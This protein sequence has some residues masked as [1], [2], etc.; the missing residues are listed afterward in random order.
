MG[1]IVGSVYILQTC[2]NLKEY[3]IFYPNGN[4]MSEGVG[5]FCNERVL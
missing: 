4:V 3:P 2:P 1:Q 5:K